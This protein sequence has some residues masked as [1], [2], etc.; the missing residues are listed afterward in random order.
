LLFVLCVIARNGEFETCPYW[1][2]KGRFSISRFLVF[3]FYFFDLPVRTST[4]TPEWTRNHPNVP[5]KPSRGPL[6]IAHLRGATA[7][8]GA[9]GNR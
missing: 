3:P 7:R 6:H 8:Q 4:E 2:A 1:G 5:R 9:R